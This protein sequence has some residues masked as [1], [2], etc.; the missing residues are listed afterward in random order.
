[1]ITQLAHDVHALATEANRIQSDKNQADF[2]SKMVEY[3]I[4]INASLNSVQFL[5]KT[6]QE[7]SVQISELQ[8]INERIQKLWEQYSKVKSDFNDN[9]NQVQ[10]LV[11]TLRETNHIEKELNGLWS[12]YA[13]EQIKSQSKQLEL[14][15]D[16]LSDTDQNN[17]SRLGVRLSEI[18][19]AS[20]KN[21]QELAKFD[22]MKDELGNILRD[23][24]AHPVVQEFI[25][26]MNRGQ[27]VS[28]GEVLNSPIMLE[29]CK[30]YPKSFQVIIKSSR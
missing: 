13:T 1:M 9:R 29:F 4:D 2:I 17:A 18:S 8:E 15:R 20:L 10:K 21:T 16:L 26:R 28:F 27:D 30:K 6:L 12:R 24:D 25:S 22:R 19:Q 7:R 11:Y 23:I 5:Y 14:F 3:L